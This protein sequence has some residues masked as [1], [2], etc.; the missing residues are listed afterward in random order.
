MIWFF[1]SAL[2]KQDKQPPSL[3]NL[4]KGMY[5]SSMHAYFTNL[6]NYLL[7][8]L[9]CSTRVFCAPVVTRNN[10]QCGLKTRGRREQSPCPSLQK[11]FPY[12]CEGITNCCLWLHAQI[13]VVRCSQHTTEDRPSC[14]CTQAPFKVLQTGLLALYACTCRI[15]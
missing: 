9:L 11:H 2:S 8:V 13:H 5:T 3:F 1:I 4:R 10:K 6:F 12:A 7:N 15:K 14:L